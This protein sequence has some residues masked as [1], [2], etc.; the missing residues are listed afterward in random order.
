MKRVIAII[1]CLFVFASLLAGCNS[2]TPAGNGDPSSGEPVIGAANYTLTWENVSDNS[3]Y[4]AW[5]EKTGELT[6][7]Y[8]SGGAY[9][10]LDDFSETQG[11]KLMKGDANGV[12]REVGGVTTKIVSGYKLSENQYGTIVLKFYDGNAQYAFE[13]GASYGVMFDIVAGGNHHC[14]I[15]NT[16]PFMLSGTAKL[17]TVPADTS[18]TPDPTSDP[19]APPTS[20]TPTT[21]P[22]QSTDAPTSEPPTQKP[23]DPPTT[24]QPPTDKPT[25]PPTSAKNELVG[26]W[27]YRYLGLD[28]TTTYIYNFKDDGSFE[29]F[30]NQSK[31]IGNYTVSDGKFY[32][33]NLIHTYDNT[34]WG[35]DKTIE[36]TFGTDN[37]GAYLQAT[38]INRDGTY[39]ELKSNSMKYHKEN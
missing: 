13:S 28:G 1:L 37:D 5:D 12:L 19:T 29:Y 6:V 17:P 10:A 20:E 4:I 32:L 9:F 33:T 16:D 14:T 36:Y 27:A 8:T 15:A 38:Q 39:F 35:E 7:T 23:T 25:D 11:S 24:T 22:G 18:K 31:I 3:V 26:M 2:A 21:T 34:K 30:V